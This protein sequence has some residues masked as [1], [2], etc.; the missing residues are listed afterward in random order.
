M[1]DR[2]IA[3]DGCTIGEIEAAHLGPG[4][5]REQ[6]VGVA[7]EQGFWQTARLAAKDEGIASLVG[8]I[9]IE[10]GRMRGEKPVWLA[11]EPLDEVDPRVDHLPFQFV[12]VVETRPP[13]MSVVDL[14]P[15]WTH[16]PHLRPDCHAGSA[17]VA[18]VWGY[19]GLVENNVENGVVSHGAYRPGGLVCYR[20]GK[21][22]AVGVR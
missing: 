8:H 10:L 5:N 2:L 20:F 6:T 22:N 3:Y 11:A 7:I 16:Q 13:E 12:P 1:T 14:E 15:Q 19:F 9:G 4:R 21:E 17:N 18:R